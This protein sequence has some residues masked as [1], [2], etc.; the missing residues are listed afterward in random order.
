MQEFL[1]IELFDGVWWIFVSEIS[2]GIPTIVI[3]GGHVLRHLQEKM[4]CSLPSCSYSA[5]D[6]SSWDP[7]RNHP[8]RHNIPPAKM[9][10]AQIPVTDK[11][12]IPESRTV[13]PHLPTFPQPCQVEPQWHCYWWPSICHHCRHLP[14]T[15]IPQ[16]VQKYNLCLGA[17]GSVNQWSQYSKMSA[18]WVHQSGEV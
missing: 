17:V 4:L 10:S 5:P 18:T 1:R 15:P 9:C 3:A 16:R 6:T 12:H 2:S 11:L 8:P 14:Q 13:H 7:A